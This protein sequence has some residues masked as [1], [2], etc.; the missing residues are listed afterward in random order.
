MNLHKTFFSC[1][2]RWRAWEVELGTTRVV[3]KPLQDTWVNHNNKKAV[4]KIGAYNVPPTKD[5]LLLLSE[6]W[7]PYTINIHSAGVK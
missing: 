5:I 7:A 4:E 3:W 6:T 2:E 1:Q